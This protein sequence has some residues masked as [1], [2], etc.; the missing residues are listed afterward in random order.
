MDEDPELPV[1]AV[2]EQ[3]LEGERRQCPAVLSR[4]FPDPQ[5]VVPPA[6]FG[7]DRHADPYHGDQPDCE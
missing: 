4:G 3:G 1:E 7:K 6:K 2:S 5:C